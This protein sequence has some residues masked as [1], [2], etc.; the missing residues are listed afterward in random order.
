M[1]NFRI[2]SPAFRIPRGRRPAFLDKIR[3]FSIGSRGGGIYDLDERKKVVSIK[4]CPNV[5]EVAI[6][7]SGDWIV[8]KNM[9][10]EI[11]ISRLS[12][13]ALVHKYKR[14]P[15]Q[16]SGQLV[17]FGDGKHF[18]D[19]TEGVVHFHDAKKGAIVRSYPYGDDGWMNEGIVV[20]GTSGRFLTAA[21]PKFANPARER[22]V[23]FLHIFSPEDTSGPVE[24]IELPGTLQRFDL[25]PDESRLAAVFDV[26]ERGRLEVRIIDIAGETL[27]TREIDGKSI[28]FC[29]PT[30]SPDGRSVAVVT[31]HSHV[32]FLDAETLETRRE[33]YGPGVTGIAFHPDG[34]LVA[35]TG[36]SGFGGI[37]LP[38]SQMEEWSRLE[39]EPRCIKLQDQFSAYSLQI[40]LRKACPPRAAIFVCGQEIIY[41]AEELVGYFRYSPGKVIATLSATDHPDLLGKTLKKAMAAFKDHPAAREAVLGPGFP[42]EGERL[43]EFGVSKDRIEH[44]RYLGHAIPYAI[45]HSSVDVMLS[46][47]TFEQRFHFWL[48]RSEDDGRFYE[49][50][51]P[52]AHLAESVSDE[53]LGNAILDAI[54][55]FPCDTKI[56]D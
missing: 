31:D 24:T 26:E 21:T 32:L 38:D 42:G 56:V 40:D 15:Y 47:T 3:F 33:Y 16:D 35:L 34:D 44:V 12:D 55:S 9:S 8:T 36:E 49:M 28:F 50:H 1:A 2:A 43:A 52:H 6:S 27:A 17:S 14:P 7:V 53:E 48:C 4:T 46:I 22:G 29:L 54:K 51:W 30:W 20:A 19:A 10:G 37:V 11:V 45:D 25:S 5:S 23:S 39:G 18:L 41:E 13:G